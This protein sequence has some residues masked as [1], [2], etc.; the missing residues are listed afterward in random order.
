MKRAARGLPCA[1]GR[2]ALRQSSASWLRIFCIALASIWRMRSA[3]TPYSAASSCR[4]AASP[5]V[6]QRRWTMVRLARRAWPA[7][8]QAFV[9]QVGVLALGDDLRRFSVG[10]AR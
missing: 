1:T 10:S 4:V 7:Q 3:D 9:L 8:L 2:G 5:S 6:S